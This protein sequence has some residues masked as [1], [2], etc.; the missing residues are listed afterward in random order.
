MALMIVV[1]M[2]GTAPAASAVP[3]AQ[4]QSAA[5]T[6]SAPQ[7]VYH[8]TTVSTLKNLPLDQGSSS[9]SNPAPG[10]YKEGGVGVNWTELMGP[11]AILENSATSVIASTAVDLIKRNVAAGKIDG[12]ASAVIDISGILLDI[13]L[14]IQPTAELKSVL[15]GDVAQLGVEGV[16]SLLGMSNI[17]CSGIMCRGSMSVRSATFVLPALPASNLAKH[18]V[19]R[20]QWVGAGAITGN[21]AT[22][23][24]FTEGGGGWSLWMCHAKD[25]TC[26]KLAFIKDAGPL[27][28]PLFCT[29]GAWCD[30]S[31][32]WPKPALLTDPAEGSANVAST[33]MGPFPYFKAGEK[34]YL[35]AFAY[36]NG[37]G[38]GPVIGEQ[39]SMGG[40]RVSIQTFTETW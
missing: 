6:P 34:V 28:R 36:L 8:R 38:N 40:I 26:Q 2:A 13:S 22:S 3:V 39:L 21:V 14:G 5:S 27:T 4:A 24:T 15:R 11:E 12:S 17:G 16:T 23:G 19:T 33:I 10:E 18:T 9:Y 35:E 37:V 25:D 7:R 30:V 20:V 32:T 29:G 1:A 31:A